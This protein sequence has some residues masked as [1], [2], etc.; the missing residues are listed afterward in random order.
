MTVMVIRPNF[1]I[2]RRILS[3]LPL[4]LLL[5]N[6]A[7]KA[8]PAFMGL[9]DIPGGRFSSLATDVSADGLT[10]V[11]YS[12]Y[13]Y[14]NYDYEAFRWT[15]GGGM[16]GLGVNTN[17]AVG[18]SADGS[19]VVGSLYAQAFRWTSSTG[20]VGIGTLPQ[21]SGTTAAA[22]SADGNTVVGSGYT[23]L[24]CSSAPYRWT[25]SGG[26]VALS[27]LIMDGI[28]ST[29]VDV[30]ADGSVIVGGGDGGS[31]TSVPYRWTSSGGM[32][33]LGTV[34]GEVS[35]LVRA[36][37][38]DGSVVV[39]YSG[40]QAFRW[41]SSGGMVGL[42]TLSGGMLANSS[43]AY[44]VS[45][46]GS[47]IVGHAR[48]GL[49]VDEAMIWE[50]T[51][52]MRE[53]DEVLTGYGLDLTGWSL[54]RASG[55]SDDGRV[56]TGWGTNPSGDREAWIATLYGA[57]EPTTPPLSPILRPEALDE[58][59]SIP[60]RSPGASGLVLI[61]HGWTPKFFG[62]DQAWIDDMRIAIEA[63][64]TAMGKAG[65]WDVRSYYWLEP[66]TQILPHL[67]A[68]NARP[69]GE[70][71]GVRI[72]TLGYTKFHLIGHSAGG[73]LIEGVAEKVNELPDVTIHSTF[74]D[75]YATEIQGASRLGDSST[76]SEHYV[77]FFPT[78]DPEESFW[79][80]AT[81]HKLQN[82]YNLN[83]T[84]L[85]A[86]IDPIERHSWPHEW[87][88]A[89][90]ED[91]GGGSAQGWGFARSQ[92]MGDLPSHGQFLR[93][94]TEKLGSSL[95]RAT[96]K[97]A[98][99]YNLIVFPLEIALNASYGVNADLQLRS[100]SPAWV[101]ANIVAD[102][103]FDILKLDYEFVSEAE[104]WLSVRL[105]GVE[106]RASDERYAPDGVNSEIL[107]LGQEMAPGVYNLS[108]RLDPYTAAQSEVHITDVRFGLTEEVAA[109]PSIDLR[110]LMILVTLVAF[111]GSLLLLVTRRH[112]LQSKP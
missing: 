91:P 12:Y 58:A 67:A 4:S 16:T 6:G 111:G 69:I 78:P 31:G 73:W 35:A 46:D 20:I 80:D 68:N 108:L 112:G 2:A 14:D 15:S 42:G 71:L 55:V 63:R 49:G 81:D 38:S 32:V 94:D 33:D 8:E 72:K 24:C 44:D 43:S 89:T 101:S 53:L 88:L 97:A 65:D 45:A 23:F 96:N 98:T 99:L 77:D 74:L 17:A 9:G 28:A 100:G 41:T 87:Y 3:G 75:A 51:T 93:G 85:S 61:A 103:P 105:D 10:V 30:S 92:E 39:G 21:W 25:L 22:V 19:L 82:A 95:E 59:T 11:G 66:S 56:I 86:S 102:Q 60:S 26:M 47:T 34:P 36:V 18:V 62:G 84:G 37:S 1:A 57:V 7:A 110:G 48:N 90:T 40:L 107:A 106:L 50:T 52:G 13:G 64:L 76:W 5:L 27:D 104:G 79:F 29:A 54:H 70:L 109:V 83:L